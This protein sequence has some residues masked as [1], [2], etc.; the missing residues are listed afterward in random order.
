[1]KILISGA[2]GFVGTTLTAALRTEGHIV[3]RLVRPGG[4][5]TDGDVAWDPAAAIID[6]AAMEGVEAIVN[7]SGANIAAFRWTRWQKRMLRASRIGATRVLVDSMSRLHTK[8][9]VFVSASA[10][11][12][13]GNRGDKILTESNGPGTGFLSSLASDWESEASRAELNGIRTAILRFG[14]IFSAKGGALPKMLAPFRL[15][16]GGRLGDG[17]QWLS[18][19]ALEDAIGAISLALKNDQMR[20]PVNVVAPNPVQNSE[21]TRIVSSLLRRPA[22]FHVPTFALRV[23]LGQMADE[24]FLA[25]QRVRPERLL[26]AGYAFRHENLDSILRAI[27]GKA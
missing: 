13:Y 1:M 8:P 23:L 3:A 6:A 18:W 24:L 14:V 2:S 7:L 5:G 17:S 19:V 22:F 9:R 12:Y 25:S 26:A 27:L 16:L 11:G 4:A 21:F 15:G 20:G 10:T